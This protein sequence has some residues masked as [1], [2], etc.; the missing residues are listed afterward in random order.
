MCSIFF[1]SSDKAFVLYNGYR[2]RKKIYIMKKQENF[3]FNNINLLWTFTHCLS[4]SLS[5]SFSHSPSH[6]LKTFY[7]TYRSKFNH[8]VLDFFFLISQ[9]KSPTTQAIVYARATD[10]KFSNNSLICSL[11]FF[12]FSISIRSSNYHSFFLAGIENFYK[13]KKNKQ[14]LRIYGECACILLVLRNLI[15]IVN[16]GLLLFDIR[17]LNPIYLNDDERKKN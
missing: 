12:C 17:I 2:L 9:C 3:N 6:Y 13:K 11:I 16:D 15:T 4:L 5:L 8:R 14:K 1:I 10:D 7:F